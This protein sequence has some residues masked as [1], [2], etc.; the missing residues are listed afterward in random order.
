MKNNNVVVWFHMHQPDYFDPMSKVQY[1]PW[2]RRHMLKG[3]Y[4]VA[5]MLELHPTKLNINF[6]GVLLKQMSDYADNG[7]EDSFSL[8]ERKPASSLSESEIQFIIQHFL[9]PVFTFKSKRFNELIQKKKNREKFSTDD[10]RDTQALFA[11]SAFSPLVNDMK[12]LINKDKA[13][14]EEDKAFIKETENKI[15]KSVL[16]MYRNLSDKGQ[17][18]L[19]VTPFYHP[20]LP[21]IIDTDSAKESKKDSILPYAHFTHKED[22]VIQIEHAID[23]FKKVFG[24]I[25]A[26]MWP[27]EGSISNEAIELMHDKGIKWI[28]T[29]EAVLHNSRNMSPYDPYV[30]NARNIKILFRDHAIS[31]KIG[32][33][34]NKMKPEDAADDFYNAVQDAKT[35]KI[36]ILDGENPWDFYENNGMDFLKELFDRVSD[37][38]LFGSEAKAD[39]ELSS[40]HPGSWINGFFDTWIGHRESNIAWEYLTNARNEIGE[41]KE[42]MEELYIAEGSDS[43]WW[44]SDFHKD[45]VDYSFDY[46]FRMHLIK[47]YENAGKIAPQYLYYPIKEVK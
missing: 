41:N 10:L 23:I 16:P 28:G 19:T 30:W 15:M 37:I 17:I 35:T 29:D 9:V 34:Y 7:L 36:V 47:A 39:G 20:I 43:F 38:T 1:L 8:L 12:E 31:D 40:I 32:F 5:K 45:E 33:T 25:P 18:E 14:T 21:L 27:A 22:A 13:F 3:Y 42:A 24:K 4:T 11:L 6:S 2:V 44:Y 26:G 46:L